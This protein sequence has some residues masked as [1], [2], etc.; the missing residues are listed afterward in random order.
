MEAA[1]RPVFEP[2]SDLP[3]EAPIDGSVPVGTTPASD[4]AGSRTSNPM[5]TIEELVNPASLLGTS[6]PDP[7][8][9]ALNEAAE[10]ASV[11]GRPST[12]PSSAPPAQEPEEL[13]GLHQLLLTEG[14]EDA[15]S[16]SPS[17]AAPTSSAS[18]A[19]TMPGSA[20]PTMPPPSAAPTVAAQTASHGVTTGPD[21]TTRSTVTAASA[22]FAT[23]PARPA[24]AA[25]VVLTARPT[26][27]PKASSSATTTVSTT[28]VKR[29]IPSNTVSA[30]PTRTAAASKPAAKPAIPTVPPARP[31]PAPA[32][33]PAAKPPPRPTAVGSSSV[34]DSGSTRSG[35]SPSLGITPASTSAPAGAPGSA[36]AA[37]A[38]P[39][40]G[41]LSD[42]AGPHDLESTYQP[43][44]A[45]EEELHAPPPATNSAAT[46][47]SA[48]SG[49][50]GKLTGTTSTDVSSNTSSSVPSATSSRGSS[51]ASAS[52]TSA[53]TTKS[54][55]AAL[56]GP[57]VA[58]APMDRD[59]IARNQVVERYLSGRLPLR[60]AT[61]F[62]R[63]CRD[64][65]QLLDE[66]GL[67]ERVN[68]GLRLL[69]ASGK[70]EPW[71]EVKQPFWQKPQ[72]II[73]LLVAVVAL[74]GALWYYIDSSAA[75]TQ[76]IAKLESQAL[77]RPLD[78]A[79]STREIRLLPSREGGSNTPAITIGGGA[80]QLVDFKIDESR[81]PY[82]V[83]RVTID[84]IDQGRVAVIS[85]LAKDS[86]GHLRIALNSSA[87]G[88][89]NYQ[90]TIEGLTWRGDAEP[91][92]WITIGVQ[93]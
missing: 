19:A 83:F 33:P 2:L 87:L 69:E 86:N 51:A 23:G 58:G 6:D 68:A 82:K 49:R 75:K 5:E 11:G 60:G 70:P 80:A 4:S 9:A 22:S 25:A 39:R 73:G 93:R 62:E 36:T 79:T 8:L 27:T 17:A 64:N 67:A 81:S 35:L 59:F 3:V 37:A 28:A 12:A 14:A 88:P 74:A 44:L 78:P 18:P 38:R 54:V 56:S 85:E 53:S 50:Y 20:A 65:P 92:S 43:T 10:L 72:I 66:L 77:E 13:L 71:Q 45:F 76:R 26:A 42:I 48:V 46:I 41:E 55:S 91:D 1:S 52:T 84:R 24:A 90:L 15:S 63:F 16:S 31:A 89:G 34:S 61:E 32:L 7:L 21:S 57:S 30:V 29:A 40:T 47:P